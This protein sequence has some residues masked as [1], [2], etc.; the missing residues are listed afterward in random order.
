MQYL[1]NFTYSILITTCIFLLSLLCFNKILVR[2][3][4]LIFAVL[5]G[6]FILCSLDDSL[7]SHN[8]AHSSSYSSKMESVGGNE[9]YLKMNLMDPKHN[10][11]EV[12]KQLILL[13][14]HL[15]HKRKRCRDCMVKHYLMVEGLLEEA[16]TL[17]KEGTYITEINDIIKE[18][19]PNMMHLFKTIESGTPDDAE[20]V[21]ISQVLRNVRKKIALKYVI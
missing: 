21:R 16:I 12:A 4:I 3:M 9:D 5:F 14:D 20:Y 15:S 18:L 2:E 6:A 10:L 19:K 8:G 1:N 11:R 13:E 17:D 7:E